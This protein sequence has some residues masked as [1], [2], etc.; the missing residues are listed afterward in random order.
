MLCSWWSY[1][2]VSNEE[3]PLEDASLAGFC[4]VLG[5]VALHKP[6]RLW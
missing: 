3:G 4:I 2:G 5:V 1:V 6:A